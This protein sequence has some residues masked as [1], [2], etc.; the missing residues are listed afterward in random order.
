MQTIT[1]HLPLKK[2]QT[3]I[4]STRTTAETIRLYDHTAEHN[5]ISEF[6]LIAF[7]MQ[8]ISL[9]PTESETQTTINIHFNTLWPAGG[10]A[11]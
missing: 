6:T 9:S 1:Y 11:M 2:N 3:R 7:A 5:Y 8:I 10:D 4:P